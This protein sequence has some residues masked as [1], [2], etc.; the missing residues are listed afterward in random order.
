MTAHVPPAQ[1][2]ADTRRWLERAVIGLNLCP[3]AKAVHAKAQ[4]HWAVYPVAD[5]HDLIAMLLAEADA[6]AACDAS[7][8]D[9]TLLIAPNTLS[10]F[11][12]FNDLT[13]RAERKLARVGFDGVLQL[14][15]FH[16]QFQFGGTAT[17]DL[18]N[19]TNRAPYPTLHLLREDSVT[20]AVAAFPEAE[21]I[22]GRNIETLEALG[23]KGW[24]ALDV[25]PGAAAP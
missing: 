23:A 15:S 17:S 8:R 7:V 16:P 20:R 25:G 6:L 14:A 12:D 4:I 3:F 1:A 24:I 18:G 9:T 13:A 21:A 2:I 5:E 22:F 11:L 19:A 10:D